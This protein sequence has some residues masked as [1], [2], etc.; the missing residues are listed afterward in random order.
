MSASTAQRRY[1]LRLAPLPGESFDS[2]LGAYAARLGISVQGLLRD[3]GDARLPGTYGVLARTPPMDP[4]RLQVAS[5][6]PP[7]ALERLWLPLSRYRERV[8][9]LAHPRLLRTVL[10][11]GWCRFCP[12]CQA[13]QPGRWSATW[14]LPW[15]QACPEHRRLLLDCC[16]RCDALQRKRQLPALGPT[17][18]PADACGLRGGPGEASR[19]VCRHPLGESDPGPPASDGLLCAQALF[20]ALLRD[21]ELAATKAWVTLTDTLVIMSNLGGRGTQLRQRQELEPRQGLLDTFVDAFTMASEPHQT[22]AAALAD[23]A[24]ERRPVPVPPR[25]GGAS[26]ALTERVL[27]V[28]AHRLGA[29]ARVRWRTA[30]TPGQPVRS[31]AAV[32]RG[33][34]PAAFWPDWSLLFATDP[35]DLSLIRATLSLLICLPGSTISVDD[36]AESIGR[37]NGGPNVL[38][39]SQ[40]AAAIERAHP[41]SFAALDRL[42]AR[43]GNERIPINYARRCAIAAERDLLSATAWREICRGTDTNPGGATHLGFARTLLWETITGGMPQQAGPNAPANGHPLGKFRAFTIRMSPALHDKLDQHARRLLDAADLPHE[44]LTWSPPRD[45]AAPETLPPEPV[46]DLALLERELSSWRRPPLLAKRAGITLE[47]LRLLILQRDVTNNRV[48][49]SQLYHGRPLPPELHPENLR[50]LLDQDHLSLKQ[51]ALQTGVAADAIKRVAHHHGIS[52]PPPHRPPTHYVDAAWLEHECIHRQRTL[53]SIAVE[54]GCSPTRLATLARRHNIPVRSHSGPSHASARPDGL[55]EPLRTAMTGTDALQRVC[56]FQVIARCCSLT[57]A[58]T[59]LGRSSSCIVVQLKKLEQACGGPLVTRSAPNHQTPQRLTPLGTLLLTLA[60][61]CLGP[62]PDAPRPAPPPLGTVLASFRGHERI[63][64]FIQIT[65]HS[66][67]IT[68]A[69][70]LGATPQTLGGTILA[71][72]RTLDEP[73]RIRRANT[74]QALTP[75]GRKL[76]LQARR[77]M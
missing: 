2:W 30:T 24:E 49:R 31:D 41:G 69:H 13:E 29:L 22:R 42:A 71:L 4:T 25:W 35:H 76:L 50:R 52:T 16:P 34:V 23:P 74:P 37:E 55:P 77:H 66:D 26:P 68:A 14:R 47:H 56:R 61:K 44:P 51:I 18:L 10:P 40:T 20:Q 28:R 53:K 70:A 5:A 39:T 43:L 63:H 33:A 48:A 3:L 64:R 57:Q 1:P 45:W 38:Q 67:L 75:V 15:W 54:I 60:D 65:E 32:P 17:D 21:D 7:E 36:A 27:R 46:V 73:L 9:T 11:M 19:T 62:H 6:L 72:E 8:H 58:A 59:L 12:E